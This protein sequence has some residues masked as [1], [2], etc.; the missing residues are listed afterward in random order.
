MFCFFQ[1]YYCYFVQY[2]T[3]VL[4]SVQTAAGKQNKPKQQQKPPQLRNG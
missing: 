2:L 4:P 3:R 1:R